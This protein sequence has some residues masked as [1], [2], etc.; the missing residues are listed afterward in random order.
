MNL[1]AGGMVALTDLM[2]K[3]GCL[4]TEAFDGTAFY[5]MVSSK[6]TP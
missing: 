2:N 4:V 6:A 1:P 5:A 3:N